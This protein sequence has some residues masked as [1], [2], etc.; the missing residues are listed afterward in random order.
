MPPEGL[1]GWTD[2]HTSV[3][4]QARNHYMPSFY[5][6]GKIVSELGCVITISTTI[7]TRLKLDNFGINPFLQIL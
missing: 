1:S 7:F 5:V 4:L 6:L 3:A 2:F